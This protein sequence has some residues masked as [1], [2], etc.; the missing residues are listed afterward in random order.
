[1]Q[2]ARKGE[3]NERSRAAEAAFRRHLAERGAELLDAWL[4]SG[5]WHRVRCAAGH[6][7]RLKPDK[8]R[9][10]R[11][12]RTCE[13]ARTRSKVGE[14]EN[15]F[16]HRIAEEGFELL[17]PW[18]NSH[19]RHRARCPLGHEC[20]PRPSEFLRGAGGCA[21]CSRRDTQ[22]A[23]AEFLQKLAEL[24]CVL[25]EA[26]W[27]GSQNPH[28][29]KCA[30]G[31]ERWKRPT[32]LA[33]GEAPCSV[34]SGRDSSAAAAKFR[35]NVQNLGG[36][37]LET[38]WLGGQTPHRVRCQ[39]G[40]VVTPRP[41]AL[42]KGQGLCRKCRGLD[43]TV[44]YIVSGLSGIKLGV[45]SGDATWRLHQHRRDGYTQVVRLMLDLP[46]DEAPTIERVCLNAM[47]EARIEPIRGR[48]YFPMEALSIAVDI[49]DGW[50]R[51]APSP[52]PRSQTQRRSARPKA[53]AVSGFK[54]A[55]GTRLS[56][57]RAPKAP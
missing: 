5:A 21:A 8:A 39:R 56:W 13:P 3:R 1:M 31:H 35:A 44:F 46:E 29:I 23:R 11:L 32:K 10:D 55:R 26:E 42:S 49:V 43:W 19:H 12:C 47:S 52:R 9:R 28:L 36:E 34:C 18:K 33:A 24:G 37:V 51:T 27:R 22:T 25:L 48:E 50:I 15:A 4:G 41:A 16:R 2:D 38:N 30:Q 40:H 14:V 6:D 54:R 53:V 45:S 17:E 7:C 20:A 57:D